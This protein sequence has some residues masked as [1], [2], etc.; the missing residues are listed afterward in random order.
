MAGPDPARCHCELP[1]AGGRPALNETDSPLSL[2]GRLAE[3][4][5]L[6]TSLG[7]LVTN[8][9]A[10]D[11]RPRNDRWRRY[12]ETVACTARGSSISAGVK[13]SGSR[14]NIR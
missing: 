7:T 5:P 13:N 2:R 10:S 14:V 3:A 12:F 11:K 1:P 4:I 9:I 6:V 8:E